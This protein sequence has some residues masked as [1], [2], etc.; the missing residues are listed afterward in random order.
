MNHE[1]MNLEGPLLDAAV[2]MAE[3]YV[4]GKPRRT[5]SDCWLY[6]LSIPGATTLGTAIRY[7]DGT[8][9]PNVKCYSSDWATAGPIIERE[10]ISIVYLRSSR[11]WL[12]S[13]KEVQCF[14]G[15]PLMAA[16]RCHVEAKRGTYTPLETLA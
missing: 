2:A 13:S 11:T 9:G 5:T 6:P 8:W 1:T 10:G 14:H 4:F 12:A 3:G 15:S 7:P 16:M